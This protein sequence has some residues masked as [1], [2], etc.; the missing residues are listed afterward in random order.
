MWRKKT[1]AYIVTYCL[2]Y[3][4]KGIIDY[5]DA[6]MQRIAENKGLE[7]ATL[8][9]SNLGAKRLRHT[10]KLFIRLSLSILLCMQISL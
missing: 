6:I 10:A 1:E 5:A 4:Y 2:D 3:V 8:Y 7:C 9:K